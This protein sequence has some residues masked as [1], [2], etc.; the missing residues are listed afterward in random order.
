MTVMA[1]AFVQVW[2]V[3]AVDPEEEAARQVDETMRQVNQARSTWNV[4]RAFCF[5]VVDATGKPVPEVPVF[6]MASEFVNGAALWQNLNKKDERAKT[7]A[8]GYVR[9]AKRK[10]GTVTV[11]LPHNDMPDGLESEKSGNYVFGERGPQSVELIGNFPK[12]ATAPGVDAIFLVHRYRGP[13]PLW[14]SR[15]GINGLPVDGQPIGWKPLSPTEWSTPLLGDALAR[16][17]PQ[18]I[19]RLWRDPA[20]KEFSYI[21]PLDYDPRGIPMYIP[22]NTWLEVVMPIGGLRRIDARNLD[23][24]LHVEAPVDGYVDRLQWKYIAQKTQD[25]TIGNKALF[26]LKI[27]PDPSYYG[28]AELRIAWKPT[29]IPQTIQVNATL[30]IILNPTPGDRL[31]ERSL[32]RDETWV[33]NATQE[34]SQGLCERFP[35][36]GQLLPGIATI[37][38][39]ELGWPGDAVPEFPK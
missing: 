22:A 1:L 37:P 32:G 6:F 13:H 35:T 11:S 9:F 34:Q 31:I 16:T 19:L 14:E 5:R 2:A 20:E 8:D 30:R 7:D 18:L 26:W 28:T 3:E 29:R 23:P 12:P 24:V 33:T 39:L 17:Q 38:P 4:E 15:S 27:G 36:N 25:S 21:E 10:L